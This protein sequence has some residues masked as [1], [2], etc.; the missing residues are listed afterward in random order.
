M[1]K[2]DITRK[3]RE[4]IQR[5]PGGGA[6]GPWKTI[7]AGKDDPEVK[8]KPWKFKD[9]DGEGVR[10]ASN[11]FSKKAGVYEVKVI[12]PGGSPKDSIVLYLGKAGGDDTNSSLNQ[13]MG[14][15]MRNGSHKNEMYNALLRGGCKIQVR[16]VEEGMSTRKTTGEEKCKAVESYYLSK[17]DYAA[18]KLENGDKRLDK[19]YIKVNGKKVPI[20]KFMKDNGYKWKDTNEYKGTVTEA[21]KAMARTKKAA[22]PPPKKTTTTGQKLKKDGTLDMRYKENK[23]KSTNGL[24][25]SKT[26]KDGTPDMRYKENKNFF[27]LFV[28]TIPKSDARSVSVTTSPATV[29][30]TPIKKD[31]TPD[32]RYKANKATYGSSSSSSSPSY[33][34]YGMRQTGSYAGYGVPLTKSGR[35]D[36]RFKINKERFG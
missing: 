5:L 28:S 32:M 31:G 14:Q 33:Y 26:K 1:K 12:P 4:E 34:S 17:V 20:K 23:E 13:R 25:V 27:D 36:M 19:L 30:E 22:R 18:N 3:K 2:E 8:S 29:T 7:M 24:Y 15:Y 10:L 6:F 21:P 16:V 11:P 9:R 35:P